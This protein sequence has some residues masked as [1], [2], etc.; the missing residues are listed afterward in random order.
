ML[1]VSCMMMQVR[2]MRSPQTSVV[3]EI[4]QTPWNG[5]YMAISNIEKDG[6]FIIL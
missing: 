5:L 2:V 4:C 6:T 3:M 1:I